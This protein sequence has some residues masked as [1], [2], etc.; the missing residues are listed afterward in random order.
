MFFDEVYNL[1]ITQWF[2]HKTLKSTPIGFAAEFEHPE[3]CAH[4]ALC[5]F[6]AVDHGLVRNVV[7]NPGTPRDR[8]SSFVFLGLYDIQD[9][10]VASQL[11]KVT[12]RLVHAQLKSFMAVK[13]FCHG[14]IFMLLSDPAVTYGE[15]IALGRWSSST[16]SN[17]CTWTYLIVV[18]PA[19]LTPSG[20]PDCRVLP[21]LPSC[22][23]LFMGGVPL[24]FG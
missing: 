18:I 3:S 8:W 17:W 20:C 1:L 21:Y 23:K 6:W 11:S 24:E 13:S 9:E 15:C 12:R 19:V 22:G 2:Q 16:N 4:L 14:A 10:S 7:G 5:C